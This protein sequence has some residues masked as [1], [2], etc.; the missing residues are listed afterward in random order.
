MKNKTIFLAL[1]VLFIACEKDPADISN[2]GGGTK[3]DT[4]T[5][6]PTFSLPGGTGP[7]TQAL[8]VSSDKI[9]VASIIAS[10]GTE[11]I[12]QHGHVWSSKDDNPSVKARKNAFEGKTELGEVA[13]NASFPY[14]FSS[15]MD[16]LNAETQYNVR[17]YVTTSK[18]TE[19]STVSKVTSGKFCLLT[20]IA[21]DG[22]GQTIMMSINTKNQIVGKSF[23]DVTNNIT[24]NQEGYP[25]KYEYHRKSDNVKSGETY[26]YEAGRVKEIQSTSSYGAGSKTTYE[27]EENGNIKKETVESPTYTVVFEY[28]EN[29]IVSGKSSSAY[30]IYT[31]QDGNIVKVDFGNGLYRLSTYD[32]NGNQTKSQLYQNNTLG[33]TEEYEYDNK[34]NYRYSFV[35]FRGWQKQQLAK[36]AIMDFDPGNRYFNNLTFHKSTYANSWTSRTSDY[37]YNGDRVTGYAYGVIVSTLGNT[38]NISYTFQYSGDCK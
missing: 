4:P 36:S 31:I 6:A 30:P 28:R 25:V 35:N 1:V 10:Q 37:S 22:A 23:G 18:G 9:K 34:P 17:A 5:I 38:V 11:K 16:N 21:H 14:N 12:I 32:L 27:Y 26:E 8:E 15:N 24:Y 13:S 20:G 3:P 7:S 29:K 33:S 2:P 19:Y